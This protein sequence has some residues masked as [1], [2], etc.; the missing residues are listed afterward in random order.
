MKRRLLFTLLISSIGFSNAQLT[1]SN[2]PQVGES[3][4]LYVCDSTYTD[5]SAIKGDGVTWDFSDI[6]ADALGTTKT[7]SVVASSNSDFSGA[8][9]VS[10]ISDFLSTYWSSDANTRTSYGFVFKDPSIGDI[11]ISFSSNQELLMNYPFDLNGSLTDTY[12]GT[13]TN[14][15][16]ASNGTSCTG[17]IS[18]EIDGNG[19]LKLPGNNNFS[20]VFRHKIVETS[21]SNIDIPGFG[22]SYPVKV[23]RTQYDYYDIGNSS[24]PIFSYINISYDAT[25]FNGNVKY[26]LSTVNPTINPQSTA[27]ITSIDEIQFHIYPNPSNDFINI[28]VDSGV[29]MQ[30]IDPNGREMFNKKLISGHQVIDISMLESG[31]YFVRVIKNGKVTVKRLV[32]Q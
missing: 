7:M 14:Q 17:N 13:L 24:F 30:I 28:D 12:S 22:A 31:V 18:S 16:M 26:I 27:G 8:S 21:N 23:I 3:V 6:T 2:E 32:I 19:T 5:A 4:L 11:V 10:E 9:F 1:Q 25:V 29:D 20:N 15:Q